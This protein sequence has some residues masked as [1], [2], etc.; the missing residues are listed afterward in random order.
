MNN[1]KFFFYGIISALGAM[2]IELVLKNILSSGIS[3]SNIFF[4]IITPSLILFA[5]V[6]ETFKFVVIN[7][8]VLL[9]K[10]PAEA[11]YGVFLIGLGFSLTEIYLAFAGDM[12][13]QTNY[14]LAVLGILAVHISTSLIFG[15]FS[16]KK[17]LLSKTVFTA[18]LVSTTLLHLIYN[19]LIIYSLSETVI[20]AYFFALL[21]L[22]FFVS[23]RL[24]KAENLP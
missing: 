22:S 24:A 15:Y 13:E 10:K 6:E 4:T 18:I 19:V 21:L 16:F 11:F 7:K 5:L 14:L 3:L 17:N 1:L 23:Y 12:F 9:L 8:A 2:I 20:S